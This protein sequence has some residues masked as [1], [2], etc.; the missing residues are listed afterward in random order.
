VTGTTTTINSGDNLN[1]LTDVGAF[2]N[3]YSYYG[4]F[5]MSGNVY[6]WN[7][8]DGVSDSSRGLRGGY[9]INN[10]SL[11]SS[12]GRFTREPSFE[13][14]SVGFRLA[15]PVPEPA[16]LGMASGGLLLAGGWWILKRRPRART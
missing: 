11:V 2:T 3:T 16:T 6:D 10:A 9:W 15:S 12:A 5:D 8:L 7:D 4:A 13:S 1:L 14:F